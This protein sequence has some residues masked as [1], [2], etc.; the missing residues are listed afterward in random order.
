MCIVAPLEDPVADEAD[1]CAI[2]IFNELAEAEI[3]GYVKS[4]FEETVQQARDR[5]VRTPGQTTLACHQ[6]NTVG[7]PA[8]VPPR[9]I[10]AHFQQEVQEQTNDMLRKGRSTPGRRQPIVCALPQGKEED[11][12]GYLPTPLDR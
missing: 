1:E 8:R 4:C 5:F 2:P 7:S 6:I 3:P 9:R 10:P 11:E 12:Q